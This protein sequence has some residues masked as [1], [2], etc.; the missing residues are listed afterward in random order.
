MGREMQMTSVAL[1]IIWYERLII[2]VV[3]SITIMMYSYSGVQKN[4]SKQN[5]FVLGATCRG[6]SVVKTLGFREQVR[7]F[8]RGQGGRILD[9]AEKQKRKH[10]CGEISVHM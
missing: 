5:N 9:G 2:H 4:S 3:T 10:L 1:F 6:G 7:G 8:D